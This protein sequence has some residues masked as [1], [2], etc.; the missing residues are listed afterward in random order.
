MQMTFEASC[1]DF[2]K[3]RGNRQMRLFLYGWTGG[4][5]AEFRIG[6]SNGPYGPGVSAADF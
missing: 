2:G 3:H 5:K 1:Q 6:K 4:L